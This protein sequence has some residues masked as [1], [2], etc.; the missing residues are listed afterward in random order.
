MRVREI[1]VAAACLA[2][3][4]AC[5]SGSG[6]GSGVTGPPPSYADIAGQYSAPVSAPGTGLLLTGTMYLFI[7]QDGG[8]FRGSYAVVGTLDEGTATG[9]V[10]LLGAVVNG[11]LVTGSDPSLQ[12]DMRPA[13]CGAV[14]LQSTGAY[15]STAGTITLSPANIPVQ[16][17]DCLD[18]LRSVSDTVTLVP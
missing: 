7:T 3:L 18:I 17:L 4:A 10:T 16:D 5:E 9:P 6:S 8:T 14:V 13:G 1:G 11:T 2:S 12:F 15:A